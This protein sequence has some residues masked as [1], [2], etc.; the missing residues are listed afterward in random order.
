MQLPIKEN[1]VFK[2][3]D[4]KLSKQANN[5]SLLDHRSS[6]TSESTKLLSSIKDCNALS[7]QSNPIIQQIV[8]FAKMFENFANNDL[9]KTKEEIEAEFH[10]KIN[11][12]NSYQDFILNSLNEKREILNIET[13]KDLIYRTYSKAK[14]NTKISKNEEKKKMKKIMSLIIYLQMRKIEMK[15]NYFNE[16]ERLIQNEGQQLKSMESQIIQDRIKL[17]LKKS[18]INQLARKFKDII[19]PANNNNNSNKNFNLS[20][21]SIVN[22]F[23]K[24]LDLNEETKKDNNLNYLD[25]KEFNIKNNK[26][27]NPNSAGKA[28]AL[29]KQMEIQTENTIKKSDF[30]EINIDKENNKKNEIDK[31]EEEKNKENNNNYQNEKD[32]IEMKNIEQ[33]ND[34]EQSKKNTE[35]SEN[36]NKDEEN[37]EIE[38]EGEFEEVDEEEIEEELEELEENQ[39]ELS[40][41]AKNPESNKNSNVAD[42]NRDDIKVDNEAVVES[43]NVENN[44]NIDTLN[45]DKAEEGIS[46]NDDN[47]NNND[48]EKRD[49]DI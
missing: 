3:S 31:I 7:D 44:N 35:K 5:S 24:S 39:E 28:S 2:F 27:I 15:L 48:N 47:S 43:E 12:N 17:A 36:I 26:S 13:L 42:Y 1:V 37:N 4:V 11:P 49:E 38:E 32:D 33:V 6:E 10:T 30:N 14:E 40:E 18:E 41:E 25:N 20:S 8:F 23:E 45:Y 21:S 16:F 29:S 9:K 22:N 34:N 46:E 19:N